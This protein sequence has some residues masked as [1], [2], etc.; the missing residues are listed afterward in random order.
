VLFQQAEDPGLA[1]VQL[2]QQAA[3]LGPHV[4]P[5]VDDRRVVRRG[6][7]RPAAGLGLDPVLPRLAAQLARQRVVGD[8][9]A[10]RQQADAGLPGVLHQLLQ[11]AQRRDV[12]L[13]RR[14]RGAHPGADALVP[15][16]QALVAQ[17]AHR[18]AQRVT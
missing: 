11:R 15:R 14:R 9:L 10:V 13:R 12:A 5:H 3:R 17:L 1:T 8:D 7:G 2:G 16:D 4:D 18:L 6:I